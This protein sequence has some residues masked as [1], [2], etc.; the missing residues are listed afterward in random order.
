LK[1]FFSSSEQSLIIIARAGNK[2]QIQRRECDLLASWP[3]LVLAALHYSEM[4][5]IVPVC[6]EIVRQVM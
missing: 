6:V 3:L 1:R 5:S 4:A 2:P